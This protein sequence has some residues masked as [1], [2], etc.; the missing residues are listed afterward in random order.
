MVSV[1][2]KA[3]LGRCP[4][5]LDCVWTTQ[6]IERLGINSLEAQDDFTI[7]KD[8]SASE[9]ISS[10][11]YDADPIAR[12]LDAC[13]ENEGGAMVPKDVVYRTFV[14]FVKTSVATRTP[15]RITTSGNALL[16]PAVFCGLDR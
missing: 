7:V 5:P 14:N 1:I 9:I 12:F 16:I 6:L 8:Q 2:L 4:P 15:P 13:V 3:D 11:N 10:H